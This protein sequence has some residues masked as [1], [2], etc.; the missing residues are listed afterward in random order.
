MMHPVPGRGTGDRREHRP[1][2]HVLH[3]DG[4]QIVG[5]LVVILLQI[6]AEFMQQCEVRTRRILAIPELH[7]NTV[8]LPSVHRRAE[9]SDH[10]M[11]VVHNDLIAP[12][13]FAVR[14][15]SDPFDMN[16]PTPMIRTSQGSDRQSLSNSGWTDEATSSMR[17]T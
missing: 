10:T 4:D 8:P 11:P 3:A 13:Q 12:E 6:M 16:L 2:V 15:R 7:L 9:Q 17:M 14:N 1:F 5:Q